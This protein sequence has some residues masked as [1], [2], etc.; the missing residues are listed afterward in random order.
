MDARAYRPEDLICDRY[1][2]DQSAGE[3]ASRNERAILRQIWR[4]PGLQR[5]DLVNGIGLTQQSI[6]RIVDQLESRHLIALGPPV[7]GTGRGKPSPT[8]RLNPGW[9]LS[10][11]ISLETDSAGVTVMDVS[12]RY[13]TRRIDLD[14]VG[15][16]AGLRRMDQAL[17]EVLAEFNATRDDLFGIGFGI[18]G[19]RVGGT[20]FNPPVPLEDWALIDLGPLLYEFFGVPVWVENGANCSAL[21]EATLGLGRRVAD[22]AYLSFNYGFGGA[23]ISDGALLRGFRGNAGEFSAIL[24]IEDNERRPALGIL[25]REMRAQGV[26]IK[27]IAEL[28]QT[29]DPS[30]P[31][32]DAWVD[33]ALPCFNRVVNALSAI[34][35]PEVIVLGGQIPRALA[36]TFVAGAE[37]W[38]EPRFGVERQVPRIE[39]SELDDEPSSI[40]SSTLP[41]ASCLL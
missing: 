34:V 5:S 25:L 40:G 8:I 39:I 22:F 23:V 2:R 19:F 27:S 12:G 7:P 1:L 35:D 18:T 3:V 4:R 28:R 20:R 38:S 24:D 6:H 17:E 30:W 16:L 33:A 36:K 37:F 11:G 41:I 31:G 15:R 32:V 29:F 13:R 26:E 21:A 14:D 10:A 9:G